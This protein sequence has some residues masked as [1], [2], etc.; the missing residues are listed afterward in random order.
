[1]LKKKKKNNSKESRQLITLTNNN[2]NEEDES[3]QN[4]VNS[5]QSEYTQRSFKNSLLNFLFFLQI[6]DNDY[7]QL[8]K[9][10]IKTMETLVCDYIIL[11]MKRRNLSIHN[12]LSLCCN[13]TINWKQCYRCSD[14]VAAIHL[15]HGNEIEGVKSVQDNIY[16]SNKV[17][18]S[19]C[20]EGNF[21]KKPRETINFIKKT[22]PNHSNPFTEPD[23]D[24]D[25][26]QMINNGKQLVSY[27][28]VSS[29]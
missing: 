1:M 12:K 16:D 28:E 27:S 11:D 2:N 29:N 24:Q 26:K 3:Y 13:K 25:I 6:K 9:Y 21:H 23:G 8:L 14:I 22:R 7:S 17:V 19:S 20:K 4:F 15:K 5:L 10:D 18:V